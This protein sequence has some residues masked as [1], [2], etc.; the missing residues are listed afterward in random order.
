[1]LLLADENFPKSTV[2]A[3]RAIALQWR[4]GLQRGGVILFRLHPAIAPAVSA[5]VRAALGSDRDWAGLRLVV[6]LQTPDP[7][8]PVSHGLAMVLETERLLRRMLSIFRHSTVN[9]GSEGL[10]VIVNQ[11]AVVN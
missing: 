2:T 9:C 4:T 3:L 11:H 8:V 5:L 10:L 6:R 7:D 1:M